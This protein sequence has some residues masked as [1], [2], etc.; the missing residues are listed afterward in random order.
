M[1]DRKSV[2]VAIRSHS[3]VTIS[4]EIDGVGIAFVR[5]FTPDD[6]NPAGRLYPMAITRLNGR[7]IRTEIM[8]S[9]E[10]AAALRKALDVFLGEQQ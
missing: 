10:A 6:I 5:P 9:H 7:I 2:Q 4:Q 8:L 3:N 1:A